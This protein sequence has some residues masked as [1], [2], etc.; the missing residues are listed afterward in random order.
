VLKFAIF[1]HLDSDG[2]PLGRFFESV[3]PLEL[4]ER[5]GFY[6]YHLAEH[7][8]TPLGMASSPSVF[9]ASAIQRTRTI[10]WVRLSTYCRF[11]TRCACTK[12]SACS[13][14]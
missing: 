11:T 14:T 1:D 4:I 13:T 6:G 3:A 10:R 9:L 2:G 7:H 8:S 12:K 5:S